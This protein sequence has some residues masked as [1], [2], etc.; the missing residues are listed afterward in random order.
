MISRGAQSNPELLKVRL[1]KE[2]V[3]MC[4][5]IHQRSLREAPGF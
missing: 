5:R 1:A 2:S 4:E 3:G